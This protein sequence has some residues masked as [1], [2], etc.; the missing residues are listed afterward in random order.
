MNIKEGLKAVKKEIKT[1]NH[2]INVLEKAQEKEEIP[3]VVG[4][5]YSWAGEDRLLVS[6]D[7]GYFIINREGIQAS[8]TIYKTEEEVIKYM[9][10]CKYKYIGKTLSS[11]IGDKL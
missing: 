10:Q 11:L 4:G 1:L 6:C 9:K 5:G 8:V 7:V 3:F 2:K